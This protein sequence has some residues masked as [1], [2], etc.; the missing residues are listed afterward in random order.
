MSCVSQRT[1][2]GDR[3]LIIYLFYDFVQLINFTTW[4]AFKARNF[5]AAEKAIEF[6]NFQSKA[7]NFFHFNFRPWNFHILQIVHRTFNLFNNWLRSNNQI[8]KL[9]MLI[10]DRTQ[11]LTIFFLFDFFT[12]LQPVHFVEP[13]RPSNQN[14][15]KYFSFHQ[16]RPPL[17][18]FEINIKL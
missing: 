11:T 16:H 1:I 10:V 4:R 7:I 18:T 15:I 6:H 8:S 12:R 2:T 3:L 14:E 17:I 9:K 13:R 5:Y